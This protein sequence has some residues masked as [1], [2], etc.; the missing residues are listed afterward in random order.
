MSSSNALSKTH[1]IC[2]T[3]RQL[4]L[5]GTSMSSS[6]A[7][8]K[9]HSICSTGRQLD[10]EG[11]SMSSSNAL[12]KTHSIC[13]TGRQLDLEGTN[14]EPGRCEELEENFL[15]T[16]LEKTPLQLFRNYARSL[17]LAIQSFID[18]CMQ[19]EKSENLGQWV[20]HQPPESICSQKGIVFSFA[21]TSKE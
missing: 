13:S 3:G 20:L 21:V 2:S 15:Q 12:S 8:S 16:L 9:T 11:T 18:T 1:S 7:L 17:D 4:D 6:N 5:E 10:L 19:S 14:D